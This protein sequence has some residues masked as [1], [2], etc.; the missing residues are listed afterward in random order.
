MKAAV[1]SD[2][3]AAAVNAAV[4]LAEQVFGDDN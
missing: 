2:D 1:A 3:G 4:L